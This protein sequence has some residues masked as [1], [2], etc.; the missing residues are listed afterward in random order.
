MKTLGQIVKL[1]LEYMGKLLNDNKKSG[2]SMI[3]FV[4]TQKGQE[5]EIEM[6]TLLHEGQIDI[7]IIQ[8]VLDI[9]SKNVLNALSGSKVE[10]HSEN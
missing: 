1:T 8:K 5:V 4:F 6:P 9:S 10:G 3:V 7:K 2:T